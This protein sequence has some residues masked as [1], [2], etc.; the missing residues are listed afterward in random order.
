MISIHLARLN[1][2][3]EAISFSDVINVIC[4]Q[5]LS[6]QNMDFDLHFNLIESYFQPLSLGYRELQEYQQVVRC[7]IFDLLQEAEWQRD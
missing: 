2:I 4:K 6:H 7:S 1:T 3:T 5:I